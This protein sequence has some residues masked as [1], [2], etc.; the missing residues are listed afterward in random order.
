MHGFARKVFAFIV[1]ISSG[2]K[3][4]PRIGIR[5]RLVSRKLISLL[6]RSSTSEDWMDV[7]P[8]DDHVRNV[9]NAHALSSQ[10]SAEED[11]DCEDRF[12]HRGFLSKMG[13][14]VKT[15]GV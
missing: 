1:L 11:R 3:N 12:L 5:G 9:E 8:V 13:G 6:L 2:T 4:L 10:G 7:R 15:S 14:S